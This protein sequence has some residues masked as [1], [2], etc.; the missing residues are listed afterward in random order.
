[1]NKKQRDPISSQVQSESYLRAHQ[2][3]NSVTQQLLNEQGPGATTALSTHDR[4][5][6]FPGREGK[7]VSITYLSLL[8]GN[9]EIV[10]W[11]Y[12]LIQNGQTSLYIFTDFI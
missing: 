1:M 7:E 8:L 9:L 5:G 10:W 12:N 2:A 6:G 3:F 4:L 11:K